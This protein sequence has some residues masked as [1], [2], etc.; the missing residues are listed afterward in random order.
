MMGLKPDDFMDGV[1]IQTAEQ[2]L[3]HARNCK[4][5]MFT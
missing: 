1:V 5:N 3:R 4:I 2:Y